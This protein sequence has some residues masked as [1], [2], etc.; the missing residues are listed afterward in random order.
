MAVA[1]RAAG[2]HKHYR[3]PAGPL[4][5]LRGVD[6]AVDPGASA[7][8]TGDSGSGKSTLLNVIAGLD[9]FRPG[10]LHVGGVDLGALDETELARYR[11]TLGMVFQFH[12][13]LRDF[14]VL[15]NLLIPALIRG[16]RRAAARR[17]ARKLLDAVG[18]SSRAAHL[19]D[20]LSGGERQRV[21][22]ARAVVGEPGLVLADEPTGNLDERNSLLVADLL[23]DLV[24]RHATTLVLVTHDAALAARADAVYRLAGGVLRRVP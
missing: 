19:P 7:A 11:R 16:Q 22:V 4:P 6:L 8:I 24:R 15:D 17:R 2:I 3:S 12:H 10:R 9:H 18:L 23:F 5:V 21:A 13:L 1:V 14:N 20:E